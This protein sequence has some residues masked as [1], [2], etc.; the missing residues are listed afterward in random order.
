MG[1]EPATLEITRETVLGPICVRVDDEVVALFCQETGF[2]RRVEG[3]VP[4]GFPAVWLTLPQI[5]GAIQRELA[6]D[7]SVPVHEFQSFDYSVPLQVGGSYD[8]IV[9]L[10]RETTP[11]RLVLNAS[12]STPEG[13]LCLRAE[14]MLRIVPRPR[15]ERL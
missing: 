3:V 8:L 2:A 15:G 14:T 12:V 9:A 10:R 11:P 5:R 1:A 6:G 4:A 13:E 7:D